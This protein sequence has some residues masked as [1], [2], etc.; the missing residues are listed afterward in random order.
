MA[1]QLLYEYTIKN[2]EM[3]TLSRWIIYVK[4]KYSYYFKKRIIFKDL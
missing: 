2:N 4:S 3:Y 1:A